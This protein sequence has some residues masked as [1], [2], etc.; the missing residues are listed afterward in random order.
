MIKIA[1]RLMLAVL[2]LTLGLSA[3]NCRQQAVSAGAT[4]QATAKDQQ[5]ATPA[6]PP[7][8]AFDRELTDTA[9]A[10]AGLGPS[11]SEKVT[12]IVAQ[13]AW[14]QWFKEFDTQWTKA[15]TDRIALI[16]TWRDQEV[17]PVTGTCDTLMYPFAGPDA[18]N[19]VLFF[20]GCRRYVMFGLEPPGSMPA[21][22]QLPPAR[23]ARLFDETRRALNDLL[24]R[25]YF[26]TSRMTQDTMGR[27]L[28]GTVPLMALFLTRLD[29]RLISITPMEIAEDGQLRRVSGAQKAPKAAAAVE[30]VFVRP[31]QQPQT[32]EYFRAPIQ[33]E[34]L[35]ES[36]GVIPYLK[37]FTS[38]PMFLK[39]ASYLLH[40]T[41]FSVLR[42]VLLE[43]SRVILQDD[44]GLPLQFLKAPTW[45]VTLYGRYTKPVKD[46]T[47]GYQPDLAALYDTGKGVKPLPFS[48]GYHWKD[49]FSAVQIAVKK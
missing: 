30:M 2:V 13:P 49:G 24:E 43:G 22:D 31:G 37:T 47:Y 34:K 26:I 6:P 41:E 12:A 14:Q 23:L 15:T 7:D 28:R 1:W 4:T 36:P 3:S 8:V 35:P 48:F 46:F 42:K 45:Q 10:L 11:T 21:I 25:N 16:S 33:D 9:R 17:T 29:A 32:I 44:S 5:A 20:P 18:L 19:A 39:S 40:G 27:E 38:Y